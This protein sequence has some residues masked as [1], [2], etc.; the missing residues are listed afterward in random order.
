MEKAFVTWGKYKFPVRYV[1]LPED[2]GGIKAKVADYYLWEE[3]WQYWERGDSD[4]IDIDNTIFFYCD[5]GFISKDPTDDEI[6]EYLR[7]NL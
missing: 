6:V 7:K 2:M 3:I 1:W 4:A 5:D